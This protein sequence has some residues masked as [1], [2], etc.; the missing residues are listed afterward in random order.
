[1]FSTLIFRLLAVLCS[2]IIRLRNMA[3]AMASKTR[4]NKRDCALLKLPDEIKDTIYKY[5][6]LADQPIYLN[7]KSIATHRSLLNVCTQ[8]QQEATSIFY[9]DN[10]FRIT[11]LESKAVNFV[12][13]ADGR[14]QKLIISFEIPPRLRK[15]W[16]V[17]GGNKRDTKTVYDRLINRP[18]LLPDFL[19]TWGVAADA[20]EVEK[21]NESAFSIGVEFALVRLLGSVFESR[22]RNLNSPERAA[23]MEQARARVKALNAMMEAMKI[24]VGSKGTKGATGKENASCEVNGNF[25]D[26]CKENIPKDPVKNEKPRKK[27]GKKKSKENG[28]ETNESYEP[29]FIFSEDVAFFF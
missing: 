13:H 26:G 16:D 12:K 7:K 11:N 8:T 9:A 24:K 18:T 10:T 3:P 28:G 1:M 25:E 29:G 19:L 21:P 14:I 2:F 4:Q 5:A 23:E 15:A 22:L 27:G 17:T 20:I 6:L